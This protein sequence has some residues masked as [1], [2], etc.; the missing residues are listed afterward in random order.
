MPVRKPLP[1]K[2]DGDVPAEREEAEVLDLYEVQEQLDHGVESAVEALVEIIEDED[3]KDRYNA[4]IRLLEEKGVLRGKRSEGGDGVV[5]A[6]AGMASKDVLEL[7]KEI[8]TMF[9]A[10]AKPVQDAVVVEV[11]KEGKDG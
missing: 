6:G 11:V 10:G 9:G 1:I 4:S 2:V 8:G 7:V 5:A 3:H